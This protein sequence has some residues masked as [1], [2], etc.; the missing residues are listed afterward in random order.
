M[1][2]LPVAISMEDLEQCIVGK[3]PP[4]GDILVPSVSAIKFQFLSTVSLLLAIFKGDNLHT[5]SYQGLAF[6]HFYNILLFNTEVRLL[7]L[8]FLHYSLSGTLK[9][10]VVFVIPFWFFFSIIFNCWS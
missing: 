2:T 5:I 6:I 10:Y 9:P 7:L 8:G 4:E 1:A 3:I